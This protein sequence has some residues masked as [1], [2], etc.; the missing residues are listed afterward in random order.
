[1]STTIEPPGWV[2]QLCAICA[3]GKFVSIP[4]IPWNNFCILTWFIALGIECNC[5]I[6]KYELINSYNCLV[7]VFFVCRLFCMAF[8]APPLAPHRSIVSRSPHFFRSLHIFSSCI[9]YFRVCYYFAWNFDFYNYVIYSTHCIRFVP[10]NGH[11]YLIMFANFQNFITFFSHSSF[12]FTPFRYDILFLCVFF[13][14]SFSLSSF[15][16]LR[17]CASVCGPES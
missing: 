12:S 17:T 16:L 15:F 9:R 4:R 13:S 3:V 7:I 1:M 14:L 2:S 6:R 8:S 11:S 10:K 5:Y